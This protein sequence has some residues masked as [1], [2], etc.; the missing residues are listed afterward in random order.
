MTTALPAMNAAPKIRRVGHRGSAGATTVRPLRGHGPVDRWS[1]RARL[2]VVPSESASVGTEGGGSEEVE[3][4][5][6]ESEEVES[7]E[8]AS[9]EVESEEVESEGV[10]ASPPGDRP[11][12]GHA[13]PRSSGGHPDPRGGVRAVRLP[14]CD[15]LSS[16][17]RSRPS[18]KKKGPGSPRRSMSPSTRSG[19]MWRKA[20]MIGSPS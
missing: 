13:V 16:Q 11:P 19:P 18:R 1:S 9:E 10:T 15:H 8:V 12:T 17:D 5:E 6:V 20:S 4:E 2:A 14:P 3:S 7:E